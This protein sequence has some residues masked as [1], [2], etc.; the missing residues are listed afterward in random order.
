MVDD[1]A[2]IKGSIKAKRII[3]NHLRFNT[4]NGKPWTPESWLQSTGKQVITGAVWIR[5]L[6]AKSLVA[7]GTTANIFKGVKIVLKLIYL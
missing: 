4:I 1:K 3:G 5:N 7:N 2:V 6:T